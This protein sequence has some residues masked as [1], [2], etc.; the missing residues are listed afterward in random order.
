MTESEV[1]FPLMRIRPICQR[2]RFKSNIPEAKEIPYFLLTCLMTDVLNLI[3]VV[4]V[5][6]ERNSHAANDLREQLL[7]TCSERCWIK[8]RAFCCEFCGNEQR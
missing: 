7:K 2:G 3:D 4:S 6:L 8:Q 5:A 1:I